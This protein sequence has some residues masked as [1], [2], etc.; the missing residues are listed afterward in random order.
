[1]KSGFFRVSSVLNINLAE[2]YLVFDIANNLDVG[3]PV[4]EDKLHVVD[5]ETPVPQPYSE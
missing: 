4:R 1:M 2:I 5:A 3:K